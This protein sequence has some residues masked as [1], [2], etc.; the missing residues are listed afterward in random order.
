MLLV[1][2][3]VFSCSTPNVAARGDDPGSQH[4]PECPRRPWASSPRPRA[5]RRAA[6]SRKALC[7]VRACVAA[8]KGDQPLLCGYNSECRGVALHPPGCLAALRSGVFST[9]SPPS[10]LGNFR[11]QFPACV[12]FCMQN[13][14]LPVERASFPTCMPIFTARIA[15][16]R[17]GRAPDPS[18][19]FY[20][21]EASTSNSHILPCSRFRTAFDFKTPR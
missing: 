20:E 13:R 11:R 1:G 15:D 5:A 8:R 16:P 3:V 18:R 14:V 2:R 6:R 17:L 10:K 19:L 9:R 12:M 4:R 21:A 7:K